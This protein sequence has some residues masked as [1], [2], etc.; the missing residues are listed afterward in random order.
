MDS[1]KFAAGGLGISTSATLLLYFS[2]N[3]LVAP[4]FVPWHCLPEMVATFFYGALCR[5]LR[6]TVFEFVGLLTAG[7]IITVVGVLMCLHILTPLGVGIE[8]VFVLFI[9]SPS[10]A[11]W[12][13]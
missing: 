12:E 1:T 13:T 9:A 2:G 7:S 3:P 11:G 6:L 10:I 4:T 8:S 5:R